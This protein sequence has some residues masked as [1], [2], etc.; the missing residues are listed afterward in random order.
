MLNDIFAYLSCMM[1][2]IY[3]Y[4]AWKE[5]N[6]IYMMISIIFFFS[7]IMNVISKGGI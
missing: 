7:M 5:H 2:T 6:K 1:F 3:G 4:L